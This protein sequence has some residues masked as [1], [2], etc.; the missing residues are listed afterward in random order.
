MFNIVFSYRLSNHIYICLDFVNIWK[1]ISGFQSDSKGFPCVL[2]FLFQKHNLT[3]SHF[4]Y[5]LFFWLW[6]RE[7]SLYPNQH[8]LVFCES[9]KL[10]QQCTC[11]TIFPVTS[12]EKESSW[13]T[14]MMK[15]VIHSS[16][17][18]FGD[19]CFVPNIEKDLLLTFAAFFRFLPTT[20]IVFH[21][22][23]VLNLLFLFIIYLF[24]KDSAH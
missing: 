2:K 12:F 15:S 18:F 4:Q 19:E 13:F 8:V 23:T 3:F 20:A 11:W 9:L 22:I 6:N 16:V 17:F 21:Y 5:S 7:F 14:R 24:D 1:F 10:W